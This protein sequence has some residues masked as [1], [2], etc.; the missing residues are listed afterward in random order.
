MNHA[1]HNKKE[2]EELV[3]ATDTEPEFV[4][5][6]DEAAGMSLKDKL[7]AVRKELAAVRAERDE[8]LAGW[9]RAKADLINY[10]RMVSEDQERDK[11]RA[12]GAVVRSI[13][14]ALDSFETA[15]TSDSWQRVSAQWRDGVE[16][17]HN[18]LMKALAAEGVT[19]FGGAG[20]TFNPAEHECMSVA[21][22]DDPSKDHTVMQVLQKGYRI[23]TEVVRPAKV[24]VA[25]ISTRS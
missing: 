6:E 8:H 20:D 9:Q 17:I 23:G 10:R 19:V 22:T 13:I 11:A 16:R 18:Q 2:D 15:L 3:V 21:Q 12:K 7:T 25:Q 5:D 1:P 4:V 24:V 14:P